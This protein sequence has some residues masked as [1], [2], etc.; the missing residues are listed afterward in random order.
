[1]EITLLGEKFVTRESIC[2]QF[3]PREVGW[4]GI[5]DQFLRKVFGKNVGFSE[6]VFGQEWARRESS[7]SETS[8]KLTAMAFSSLN[9]LMVPGQKINKH[10]KRNV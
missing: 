7:G 9:L 10:H 4:G 6:N 5:W 8:G 1:M 3:P 2:G